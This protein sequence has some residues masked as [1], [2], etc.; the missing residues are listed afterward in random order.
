MINTN[1]DIFVA[2]N[3][4]I[5]RSTDAGGLWTEANNGLTTTFATCFAFN[6]SG[7]IFA[8]T[9]NGGVF[10]SADS[11]DSWSAVNNGLENLLVYSIA[12]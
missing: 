9:G 6:L 11:A 5:F 7:D 12:I 3:N 2:T 8:G 4:G 1:D 10:M